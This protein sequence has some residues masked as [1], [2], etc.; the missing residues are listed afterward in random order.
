MSKDE[1]VSFL[2]EVQQ[3]GRA[4][5]KIEL[6]NLDDALAA[7]HRI[8]PV[9]DAPIFPQD[10]DAWDCVRMATYCHDC[11]AIVPPAET[12]IM[13]RRKKKTRTVCGICGS[14]KISC[15]REEAL[16]KFYHLEDAPPHA[17]GKTAPQTAENKEA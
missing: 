14:K 17:G 10:E 11:R 7:V 16:R 1:K 3:E 6:S 12:T 4:S 2:T 13:R 15:G 9:S 5:G 8:L